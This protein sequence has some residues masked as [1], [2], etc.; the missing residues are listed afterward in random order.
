MNTKFIIKIDR[1]AAW[2]L[3]FVMLAYA[4][5]GFGMT[6]GIINSQIARSAHLGWLGIVGLLAFIIHTGYAISLAFKRWQIW[7]FYTK[8]IM[9]VFYVLIVGFFIYLQFF[10]KVIHIQLQQQHKLQQPQALPLIFLQPKLFLNTTEKTEMRPISLLMELFTM[11]PV[12]LEME[13][14]M[15]GGREKI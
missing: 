6:K 2:I 3:F 10:I 15:V 12:F 11:F 14:I 13:N 1:I 4:V 7:N 9:A 8:I 5:T